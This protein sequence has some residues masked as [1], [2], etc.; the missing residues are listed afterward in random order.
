MEELQNISDSPYDQALPGQQ[1]LAAK[2]SGRKSF[3]RTFRIA[4]YS[5]F[6]ATDADKAQVL[7]LETTF[8]EQMARG[9]ADGI[10]DDADQAFQNAVSRE[11]HD[12]YLA[13]VAQKM[14]TPMDC[15]PSD[16]G[17][18]YGMGSRMI[19]SKCTTRFS[20]GN[21]AIEIFVWKKTDSDYH[22]YSYAIKAL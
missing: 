8:H 20:S 11:H 21:T 2:Q 17:V 10:Y 16:T 22:L 9:D 3:W 19:R 15:E 1:T 5:G 6:L 14:G 4:R 13:A 7:Q 12:G 18:K